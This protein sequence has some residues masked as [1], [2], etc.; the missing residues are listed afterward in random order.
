MKIAWLVLLTLSVAAAFP[1]TPAEGRGRKRIKKMD[2][3]EVT[4]ARESEKLISIWLDIVDRV[5]PGD[6]EELTDFKSLPDGERVRLDSTRWSERFFT[7]AA[8]PY[9]EALKAKRSIHRSTPDT[10]DLL[11]HQYAALGLEMVVIETVEFTLIRVGQ[12]GLD[13]LKVDEK[14]RAKEI[15]K[16]AGLILNLH[17]VYI[18][19]GGKDAKYS[20]VF[21]FPDAIREG[22]RFSTH[23]EA[24]PRMMWSWANRAD[25]GIRNGQLYF[26]CFKKHEPTDGRLIFLDSDHWFD[27]QCWLPYE[28]R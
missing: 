26:L 6:Y 8:N 14:D 7:K 25:G 16:A 13:L 10:Y 21:R 3:P 27:G 5:S 20:W 1:V 11:R 22:T 24:S 2:S 4:T 12:A 15:E 19:K 28:R 9:N 23:P 18:E 17:G